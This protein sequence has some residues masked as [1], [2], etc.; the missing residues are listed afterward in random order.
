MLQQLLTHISGILRLATPLFMLYYLAP[1]FIQTY[2]GMLAS[3]V[4]IGLLVLY[5]G[6]TSSHN[7]TK[8][9]VYKPTT[10]KPFFKQMLYECNQ[11]PK[12]FEFRYAYCGD[13]L[14]MAVNNTII[15]DPL[16][17]T[18]TQEDAE[19][20]KICT[21]FADQIQ[22]TLTEQHN[23]QITKIAQILTPGAQRFIIKHEI[24]HVVANYAYKK[25]ATLFATTVIATYAGLTVA[26]T[27]SVI[28]GMIVGGIS[29][30]ALT[31]ISNRLFKYYEERNADLFAV[32]YSTLQDSLDAADFFAQH[33]AITTQQTPRI[34]PSEI[35]SGHMHGIQRAE[36]IRTCAHA[37][38]NK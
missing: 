36:Y 30:I 27:Y 15:V 8:T 16:V 10:L 2:W 14:A 18:L 1:D 32:N 5:F 25:L 37:C 22:P 33:H 38:Y 11:D 6:A 34:L 3:S 28:G 31:L 17:M 21:I 12:N 29:D 4:L 26:L 35:A 13:A 9:L 19:A 24:G 7:L 20:Q 23:K